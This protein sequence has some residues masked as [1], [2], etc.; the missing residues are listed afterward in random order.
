MEAAKEE[1]GSGD[2][3]VKDVKVMPSMLPHVCVT[4]EDG[5]IACNKCMSCVMHVVPSCG[6][7]RSSDSCGGLGC[8]SGSVGVGVLTRCAV[9]QEEEAARMPGAP[10][11]MLRGRRM[12][13]ERWRSAA[14]SLDGLLDYDEEARPRCC[15]ACAC[16]GACGISPG[17]LLS[18]GTWCPVRSVQHGISCRLHSVVCG[19]VSDVLCQ[20][21]RTGRSRPWS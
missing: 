7:H 17:H 10:A 18:T 13:R 8:F 4:D 2:A 9:H 20:K 11:L 5:T 15:R 14:I 21:R 12:E 16:P 1:H 6:C 19:C 3:E